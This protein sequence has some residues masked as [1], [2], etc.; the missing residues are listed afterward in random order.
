MAERPRVDDLAMEQARL[1]FHELVEQAG[2]GDLRR[3]SA[4][5]AG[6]TASCCPTWSLATWSYEP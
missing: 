4:A 6:R 1:A 5:P 3:R 2:P